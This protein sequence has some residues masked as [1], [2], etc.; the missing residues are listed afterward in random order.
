M[1]N[2]RH[3]LRIWLATANSGARAP[4]ATCTISD[5]NVENFCIKRR[6]CFRGIDFSGSLWYNI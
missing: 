1:A 4:L 2:N 5:Q 6:K 3:F